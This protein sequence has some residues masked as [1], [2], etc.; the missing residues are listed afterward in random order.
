VLT[1]PLSII[2]SRAPSAT[3]RGTSLL[4]RRQENPLQL[5]GRRP[6]F[7]VRPAAEPAP[8]GLVRRA[9]RSEPSTSRITSA[10]SAAVSRTYR[11]PSRRPSDFF[12]AGD[13]RGCSR[14]SKTCGRSFLHSLVESA[15]VDI[16]D[17]VG[18]LWSPQKEG[19]RLPARHRQLEGRV[20]PARPVALPLLRRGAAGAGEGARADLSRAFLERLR[21]RS[22]AL[23]V[24]VSA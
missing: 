4:R 15:S 14:S 20:A 5:D 23:G 21:G 19:G 11:P 22:E 13:E 3:R 8:L 16:T 6:P 10:F 24:C 7:S 2:R 1:D 12:S 18:H 9:E 17:L